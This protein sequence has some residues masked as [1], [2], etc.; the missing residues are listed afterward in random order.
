MKLIKI[1]DKHYN[2]LYLWNGEAHLG[3]LYDVNN[4]SHKKIVIWENQPFI[5]NIDI[6]SY[7]KT[8]VYI[9]RYFKKDAFGRSMFNLK[10]I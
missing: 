9:I 6:P 4:E 2:L 10:L 3:G 5:N 1:Q 8:W 7:I